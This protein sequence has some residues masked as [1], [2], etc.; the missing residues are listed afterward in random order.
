MKPEVCSFALGEFV[1]SLVFGTQLWVFLSLLGFEGGGPVGLSFYPGFS[2][3]FHAPL[4]RS[5][6]SICL[7]SRN[8]ACSE[9]RV[10]LQCLASGKIKI[11]RKKK[12]RGPQF[13]FEQL[14]SL[15]FLP[16]QMPRN[17]KTV[18]FSR[19]W[20]CVSTLGILFSFSF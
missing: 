19:S 11:G 12:K 2:G 10:D 20:L 4:R 9:G 16:I 3:S 17:R 8:V 13:G 14:K 18:H 15:W 7:W 1:F 5:S 6:F